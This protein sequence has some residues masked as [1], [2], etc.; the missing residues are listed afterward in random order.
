MISHR[1]I[2]FAGETET[3]TVGINYQVKLPVED[4]LAWV[5]TGDPAEHRRQF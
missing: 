1:C 4:L 2:P 3:I 5:D